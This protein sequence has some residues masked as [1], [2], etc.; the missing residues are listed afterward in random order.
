MGIS[1]DNKLLIKY[2]FDEPLILIRTE[3]LYTLFAMGDPVF[4]LKGIRNYYRLKILYEWF[5]KSHGVLW[6][7]KALSGIFIHFDRLDVLQNV[8][9]ACI[10]IK[11]IMTSPNWSIET[12]ISYYNKMHPRL[13]LMKIFEV[14]MSESL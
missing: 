8:V 14:Y 10:L 11:Q 6:K 3:L 9:L 7:N 1:T 4:F 12:S 2:N 13:N 5:L